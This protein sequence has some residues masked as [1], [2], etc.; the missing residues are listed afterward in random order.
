[1]ATITNLIVAASV[2]PS[3][4]QSGYAQAT[5]YTRQFAQSVSGILDSTL[6]NASVIG[7]GLGN[8][9]GKSLVDG[10]T[11]TLQSEQGRLREQ[12]ERGLINQKQFE[13]R[14]REA[15]V[16]FN[17][18]LLQGLD[19]LKADGILTNDMQSKIAGQFQETAENGGRSFAQTL[20]ATIHRHRALIPTL[21]GLLLG[22]AL[23][24]AGDVAGA[25]NGLDRAVEQGK[26][27][28]KILENV[29]MLASFVLEPIPGL[30]AAV[31]GG[32][33]A[34]VVKIWTNAKEETAKAREEFTRE[35]VAASRQQD[36]GDIGKLRQRAFSGDPFAAQEGQR[37]GE[38][39]E[40]FEARRLG[41][42]GIN[43]EIARVQ[44]TIQSV[45]VS[46]MDKIFGVGKEK[47]AQLEANT[48]A[49]RRLKTL[50]T[51]L[52]LVGEEAARL[53]PILSNLVKQGAPTPSQL[54]GFNVAQIKD[55]VD[56]MTGA[57]QRVKDQGL[58]PSAAIVETMIAQHKRIDE[59]LD[60]EIDKTGKN[61][62]Q[63]R[64][65]ADAI[66]KILRSYTQLITAK[67]GSGQLDVL[68]GAATIPGDTSTRM[69]QSRT[70]EEQRSIM[71]S[72]LNYREAIR[73]E[74]EKEGGA[75]RAN[76][77][78]LQIQRD[79]EAQILAQRTI[80]G[81]PKPLPSAFSGIAGEVD[82][83]Q[84][85]SHAAA[86]A[87]ATGA[88]NAGELEAAANAQRQ[89]AIALI[90]SMIEATDSDTAS[91]K[92]G[93]DAL[94]Q[95][96][97]IAEQLGDT[98]GK[99]AS[100]F[101]GLRNA[102]DGV[103]DAASGF[104]K[105]PQDIR[106]AATSIEH[107]IDAFKALEKA[108]KA[109]Q[110]SGGA[111]SM[112]MI[113]AGLGVVGGAIGILGALSSMFGESAEAKEHKQII[114]EN[115]DRLRELK[116][117]MDGLLNSASA[118]ARIS[119]NAN[120]LASDA[121]AIKGAFDFQGLRKLLQDASDMG[122]GFEELKAKA[123]SLGIELF[124]SKG[125]VIIG[126]FQQLADALKLEQQRLMTFSKSFGDQ[127]ALQQLHD[128]VFGKTT[129][130]DKFNSTLALL[131]KFAPALAS[132]IEGID[133]STTDGRR[134][135]EAALQALVE[136]LMAGSITLQQYGD[137]EGAKQLA[138]II[139]LLQDSLDGMNNAVNQVTGSL[140]NVPSWYKIERQRFL[141]AAPMAAP[142]AGG[143]GFNPGPIIGG[144]GSFVPD[145]S[146]NR[147]GT[148][149]T[150]SANV[151]I[152]GDVYVDAQARSAD[153]MWADIVRTGRRKAHVKLGNSTRW[154]ELQE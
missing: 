73:A 109:S 151:V 14:G 30:I 108:R 107:T 150:S 102:I 131:N 4:M 117:S 84:A 121:G 111:S 28:E 139:G 141:N 38:S 32:S 126:A 137:L 45:D 15:A 29:A 2:N 154:S 3:G 116:F 143:Q 128:R 1:M 35:L 19:R 40:A 31:V 81:P 34:A 63:L 37:K 142:D 90:R 61:A 23:S 39:A 48:Q 132:S 58:E 124:D 118:S 11:R 18:G 21:G 79:I 25:N 47:L 51:E 44:A 133:A 57:W 55:S 82:Q 77:Q 59:L 140:L 122:E 71:A 36:L 33:A 123:K 110:A 60:N 135:I 70:L 66:D 42:E 43:R 106:N 99:A 49:E 119:G 105:I 125:H 5:N 74:V 53:D 41:I 153:E 20:T 85:M 87:K 9:A 12:L 17:K 13:A 95:L 94:E 64:S 148:G 54:Q 86:I 114:R 136:Q 115:N 146:I 50:R 56:L 149:S 80:V 83:S 96:L 16:A 78:L 91:T 144:A 138:E 72:L 145:G 88:S 92:E 26:A 97:Q 113:G 69:S 22:Q 65:S 27:A 104:G 10:L 127:S 89:K 101:D 6:N 112:A 120:A 100:G 103:L 129:D 152:Q 147:I 68:L 75:N 52:A 93:R 8:K 67:P 24:S 134:K 7:P 76:V 62:Q 46:K 130:A 98:T